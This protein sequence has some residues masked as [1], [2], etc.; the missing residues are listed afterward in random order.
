LKLSSNDVALGKTFDKEKYKE[1]LKEARIKRITEN[2]ACD[3]C[4]FTLK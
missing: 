4:D 1:K 2:K 3:K